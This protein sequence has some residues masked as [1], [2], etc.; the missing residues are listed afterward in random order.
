MKTVMMALC[1][2]TA[3][4]RARPAGFVGV[5]VAVFVLSLLLPVAVLSLARKPAEHLTV[6]P[7]LSRLPEYL[8]SKD[9]PVGRKLEFLSTVALMW[10]TAE[11]PMGVEW[12]FI[13]DV[14]SL[15][16]IAFTS[17][18]FGAYFALWFHRRDQVRGCGWGMSA[19]RHGGVAGALTSV[20]GL[21]AG[22][23]SVAGCGV[24]VLPVLGLAFT[25]LPTDTLKFLKELARVVT[26]VVLFAMVAG[27]AWFG[28]RVG[29]SNGESRFAQSNGR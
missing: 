10:V 20:L 4:I 15:A 29:T 12:G 5:A 14:P 25:G 19:G 22:P 3:A 21:S 24:P 18:V 2:I 8:A 13:V 9:V 6:N 11:N 7:W 28:W 17:L 16:R 23:C 26:T 1:G 27:V